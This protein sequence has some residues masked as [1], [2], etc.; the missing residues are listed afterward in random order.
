MRRAKKGILDNLDHKKITNNKTF[1]ETIRLF[2]QIN[3]DNITSVE[4]GETLSKR[5]IISETL[6]TFFSDVVKCSAIR[7]SNIDLTLIIYFVNI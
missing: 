6:N 7:R 2:L 3:K 1:K 4:N 5:Q